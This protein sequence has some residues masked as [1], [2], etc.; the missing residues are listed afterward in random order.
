MSSTADRGARARRS[1]GQIGHRLGAAALAL[2]AAS[3]GMAVATSGTASALPN[4]GGNQN[5]QVAP[6]TCQNQRTIDGT[7][8]TVVL[9]VSASGAITATYSLDAP[10]A[11]DTPIRLRAHHGISSNPNV[12]ETSGTIPAGATSAVLS[13]QTLCGQID[14]K[15]VYTGN[16]DARGR[17]T[18]PYV[19]TQDDCGSTP[20]DHGAAD[21]TG[22]YDGPPD[23]RRHHDADDAH[24]PGIDHPQLR[25]P[26]HAASRDDD[27]ERR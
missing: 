15:A 5:I 12:N 9:S 18:A 3:A 16:G 8:F 6:V 17:V 11:A 23:Q 7:T 2:A 25:Q 21:H 10:R 22:P 27:P 13:S 24:H 19:T 1:R 14:V 26:E 4:C 20:S